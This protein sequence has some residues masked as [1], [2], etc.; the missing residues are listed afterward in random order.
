MC[1]DDNNAFPGSSKKRMKKEMTWNNVEA[2]TKMNSGEEYLSRH[3]NAV[4]PARQ[5]GEP[6]S[7]QYFSK[8]GQDNGQQIF[9]AFW[10]LGNYDLQNLYLSKL[11]ISN[12]VRRSYVSGRP[13]RTLRRPDYTV[14]INNEKYSV[15]RKAFYSMHGVSE[16]RVLA[17]INKTTSTETVVSGQRGKKESGRKVQDGKKSLSETFHYENTMN[18]FSV[19]F[20]VMENFSNAF[21]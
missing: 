17:V 19:E 5:I 1:T 18:T 13:S 12:N 14:I 21:F 10:E 9:N 4:V 15:F 20:D 6:C 8:I 2:K 7:C 3:T 11:V 16:E